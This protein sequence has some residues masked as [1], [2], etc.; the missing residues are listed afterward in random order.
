[1]ELSIVSYNLRCVFTKGDGVN[2]FIHRAGMLL[3]KIEAEQPEIICFQEC[4]KPHGDFL[5]KHLGGYQFIYNQ[6][7]AD[8]SGEGLAF[9]IKL[10][11]M[12]LYGLDVFWLSPTPR[13]PGSRFPIQSECPRICQCIMLR[14]LRDGKL[15]RVYNTHLD[16]VSD[17]ARILGIKEILDYASVRQEEYELPLFLLGDFNALPGSETVR[18]CDEFKELP[19]VDLTRNTG[20]TWHDFGRLFTDD[21]DKSQKID[22]IYADTETAKKPFSA[23]LWKD[24]FNGIYLSDHY[25]VVLKTEL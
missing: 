14:D 17:E 18:Y 22:Y 16:H 9:A 23:E 21:G 12:E 25:P 10:G 1:M 20:G 7:N 8:Y 24:E 15:F 11:V 5:R 4:M 19:I 3:N 6:R 13:V 2:S